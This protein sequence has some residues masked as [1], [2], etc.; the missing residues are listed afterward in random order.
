M[1]GSGDGDAYDGTYRDPEFYASGIYDDSRS[2]TSTEYLSATTREF[3][4]NAATFAP[5]SISE[6]HGYVLA[7]EQLVT[8]TTPPVI[9]TPL[10]SANVAV[11]RWEI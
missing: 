4:H 7:N 3:R 6:G 2:R 5:A 10:S 1:R 11:T 9:S 8:R